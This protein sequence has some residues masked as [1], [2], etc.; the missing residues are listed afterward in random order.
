M[1]PSVMILV[2]NSIPSTS[3]ESQCGKSGRALISPSGYKLSL[4][5]GLADVKE[6]QTQGSELRP[7]Y[8]PQCKRIKGGGWD[9]LHEAQMWELKQ[10]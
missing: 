7:R 1:Y 8:D 4:G 6:T 2:C 3:K 10:L 9:S 5:T